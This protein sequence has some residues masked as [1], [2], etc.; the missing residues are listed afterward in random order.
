MD[1]AQNAKSQYIAQSQAG[2]QSYQ[3]EATASPMLQSESILNRLNSIC[4]S[5]RE[6]NSASDA[7]AEKIV[8]PAPTPIT[9]SIEGQKAEMPPAQYFLEALN[10]VITDIERVVENDLRGNINRLHRH[11]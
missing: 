2:T 11:F 4:S 8:G 7:I 5:L 3:G 9:N 10:R 1:Y 6:L